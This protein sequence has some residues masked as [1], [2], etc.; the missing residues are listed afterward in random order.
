MRPIPKE[1][2]NVWDDENEFYR[3]DQLEI[4]NILSYYQSHDCHFNCKDCPAQYL[5]RVDPIIEI[6]AITDELKDYESKPSCSKH[7]WIKF[8]LNN[9]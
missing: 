5:G 9:V 1:F 3:P 6:C 4:D 7:D 2:F 8:I